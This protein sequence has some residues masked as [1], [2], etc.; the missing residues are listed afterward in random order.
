VVNTDSYWIEAK[1]PHKFLT[2]LNKQQA[3]ELSQSRLWGQGKTRQARVVS[4]LPEL[5]DKDR[6]VKLLLAIDQ[7]QAE[8]TGLPSVFINDFLNVQLKGKPIKN[9]WTIK[10]SWLQ[11]DN[12]IWVVDKN[13]TLQKRSVEVLFKGRDVI[14][15]DT[16]I[17]AGDRALAEKPGIASIGLSVRTRKDI[18][19]SIKANANEPVEQSSA[20]KSQNKALNKD[21][22]EVKSTKGLTDAE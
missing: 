13:K 6:Q 22:N 9:A 5:D 11:A 4:I 19:S 1:I 7:P 8:K 20:S 2:V 18:A 16:K 3:A 17:M 10:H 12:T 14:Y 15:V 21:Q